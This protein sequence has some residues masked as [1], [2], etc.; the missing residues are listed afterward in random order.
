MSRDAQMTCIPKHTARDEN[1]FFSLGHLIATLQ[2]LIVLNTLSDSHNII[3]THDMVWDHSLR[4]VTVKLHSP[5]M[6]LLILQ[7]L[8]WIFS[9]TFP[10]L[11][12][13]DM[14]ISWLPTCM[15]IIL[16]PDFPK[17]IQD[18]TRLPCY[19]SFQERLPGSGVTTSDIQPSS[20]HWNITYRKQ[21]LWAYFYLSCDN[22]I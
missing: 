11:V 3:V 12:S 19:Y 6:P 9:T 2:N 1:V 7:F 22:S 20:W 16:T 15:H 17:G 5:K 14:R 13:L 18:C 21:F 10:V 4:K 8:W